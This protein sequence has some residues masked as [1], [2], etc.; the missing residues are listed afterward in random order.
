FASCADFA[1]RRTL[2]AC[3]A[4]LVAT[5][6]ALGCR[7]DF[8]ATRSVFAGDADLAATRTALALCLGLSA[9]RASAVRE[10][11][12]VRGD[13]ATRAT[14]STLLAEASNARTGVGTARDNESAALAMSWIMA[15][16]A[17]NRR[18]GACGPADDTV[19]RRGFC[20]T[21]IFTLVGWQ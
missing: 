6:S 3:S 16:P 19:S 21:I 13:V 11:R 4:D 2:F 12:F 7:P 14:A 8:A 1:A 17:S 20:A 18:S 5:C 9:P 10:F 15:L